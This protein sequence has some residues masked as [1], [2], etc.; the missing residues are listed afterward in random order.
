MKPKFYF[1]TNM[2]SRYIFDENFKSTLVLKFNS[3]ESTIVV[4]LCGNN[5][6]LIRICLKY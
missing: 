4:F 5:N 6:Y 2:L 3:F 1:L